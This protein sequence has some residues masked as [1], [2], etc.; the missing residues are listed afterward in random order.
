MGK[1]SDFLANELLD[2]VYNAAYTPPT[3]VYLGLSTADPLDSGSGLAEP[4]GNGYARK[5]ITFGAAATRQVAQSGAV[6]FDQATG[7][8]GTITHYAIFDALTGGNMMAHGSLGTSKGVV[9]G[10]T[11]SVASGEATVSI[12]AGEVSNYLANI[13]LDFAFRNQTFSAPATYVALCTV[14]V[15]DT[16]T[17]STITEPGAGAYAR[18]QVNVNGGAAPVWAVAASRALSNGADIDFTD[19]TASWGLITALAI[20]DAASAGNL[21]MYENTVTDQ[22]PDSGDSVQIPSGDLDVALN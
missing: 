3:T 14:N 19:P 13:M 15:A 1:L 22:T 2:H 12:T 6:N 20:V 21:L 11:P 8:W 18:K 17:G 7:A 9:S 5:A 10:N 16:N 4:S